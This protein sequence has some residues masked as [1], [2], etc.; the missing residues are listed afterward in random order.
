[1]QPLLLNRVRIPHGWFDAFLFVFKLFT[2][3]VTILLL[4]WYME[5]PPNHS[6]RQAGIDER[7][8]S[9]SY[10]FAT[11]ASKASFLYY[12]AAGVLVVGGLIQLFKYSRRAAI[13]SIMFGILALLIGMF[14]AHSV[15]WPTGYYDL[16]GLWPN[17]SPEPPPI[18]L[19]VPHSR[20][21]DVA[22]RLSCFR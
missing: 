22:A 12:L 7:W 17:N 2:V 13:W 21:T 6:S 5:L 15:T 8:Y 14:L 9:A 4:I 11:V 19:S 16:A 18:T 1:M 20:L 10:D 3:C